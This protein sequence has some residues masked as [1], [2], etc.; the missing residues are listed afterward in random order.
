MNPAIGGIMVKNIKV[1]LLITL[2]IWLFPTIGNCLINELSLKDLAKASNLIVRGNVV[3]TESHWTNP[4]WDPNSKIIVTDV[5]LR[6]N[7]LFKGTSIQRQLIVQTEGGEV[8]DVGLAV[9]DMPKFSL[10]EEVIVFLS[11]TNAKGVRTV[12]NLHNGKYTIAQGKILEKDVSTGQFVNK[13][14][15]TL[16]E[17]QKEER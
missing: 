6:I 7:E 3:K 15:Q 13:I 11:P 10:S 17:L 8:G 2:I 9:E 16:K 12:T 5:T 1:I 4:T 14:R